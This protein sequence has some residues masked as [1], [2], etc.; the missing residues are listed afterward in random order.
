M[1]DCE[2][3]CPLEYFFVSVHSCKQVLRAHVCVCVNKRPTKRER[4]REREN[5]G[6]WNIPYECLQNGP[7]PPPIEKGYGLISIKSVSV[8]AIEIPPPPHSKKHPHSYMAKNAHTNTHTKVQHTTTSVNAVTQIV[9]TSSWETGVG[10]KKD[11]RIQWVEQLIAN[12]QK[13]LQRLSTN[14]K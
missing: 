4:E 13:L 9:K 10:Q 5:T 3:A 12:T 2:C 7:P 6:F 1:H 8:S 11:Q 14:R